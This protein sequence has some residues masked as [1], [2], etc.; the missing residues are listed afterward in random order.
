MTS[1]DT[2]IR[3]NNVSKRFKL[4]H[5][6]VTG[7]VKELVFFWKR[8]QYY[9]EFFA[10]KSVSME[11]K[12]GE[13]VGIIGANGAGKTTLLKMIAG[14]LP[15]DGGTLEVN[16]KVTALLALGVGVNPEFTG[17]E[18]ILYNGMLLGMSKR[19]VQR[20][21]PEIIEFSEL[22]DYVDRPFR[23]Y[24]SGMRARL[25]FATFITIE[26]DILIV[27][28]ALAT[29]DTYFVQKS[30]Q[31]IRDMCRSGATILFVSHNLTQIEQLCNRAYLM[32]EGR[33][34]EEGEP[35]TVISRYFSLA[36]SKRA[37]GQETTLYDELAI[38]GGTGD[39]RLRAVRLLDETGSPQ[40]SFLTHQKMVVELDYVRLNPQ[41]QAVN[42]FIGVH[43]YPTHEW[44]GE[45][46]S[47]QE[48]EFK[49]E[50]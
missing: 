8:Q 6:P 4:Y 30:S 32:S 17:R 49:G 46:T 14:L 18:N 44:V 5:N 21:M 33:V 40:T 48:F 13:V 47:F 10:V 12:R 28:E 45:Y 1:Q 27:D 34:E 35:S 9:K 11:V 41:V 2:A 37:T 43:I 50:I 26:P 16:G 23:T 15:V 19:E 7:P 22:G 29:G 42:V 3:L 24:S 36:M 39:V 25:L 20:K 31:R 38:S